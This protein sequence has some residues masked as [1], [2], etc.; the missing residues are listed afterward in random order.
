MARR[1]GLQPGDR[2]RRWQRD[3]HGQGRGGNAG[4]PRT[5]PRLPGAGGRRKAARPS[6]CTLYR[7]TH[8]GRDGNRGHAERRAGSTRASGE[9][10][11]AEPSSPAPHGRDRSRAVPFLAAGDHGLYRYGRAHA[12]DRALCQQ[13]RQPAHRRSL[14]RGP[15][16]CGAI[17]GNRLSRRFG[18]RGSSGHVRRGPVQRH[19]PGQR[20][21]R[22]RARPGRRSGRDHGP[23]PWRHLCPAASFRD[24]G[25]YPGHARRPC[26]CRHLAPLRRGCSHP[27][28]QP[29]RQGCRWRRVGPS[30][31][32]RAED[33]AV[34]SRRIEPWPN[35]PA[36]FPPPSGPAA[37]KAIR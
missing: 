30:P 10:Q 27:D 21:A 23:S 3:R 36:S 7:R 26:S 11:P 25:Q 18:P 6:L 9:S 4:T 1:P 28:R 31:V 24:G 33:P 29:R 8:N 34:A 14:P 16:A 32:H 22:R 12:T 37:C 13:R 17:T 20:Q 19:R 15:G 5:C 35:A 2:R